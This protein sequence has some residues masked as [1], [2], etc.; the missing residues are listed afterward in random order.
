MFKLANHRNA[1]ALL[2]LMQR[3]IARI[4]STAANFRSVLIIPVVLADK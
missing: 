2:V 3:T 4:P 1:C